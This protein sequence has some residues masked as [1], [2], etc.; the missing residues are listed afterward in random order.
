MLTGS[1]I[2]L[3]RALRAGGNGA[4]RGGIVRP[5]LGSRARRS[6]VL[7][8]PMHEIE[9]QQWKVTERD[10]RFGAP[11]RWE[12]DDVPRLIE[13][14]AAYLKRHGL[15]LPGEEKR[16]EAADFEPEAINA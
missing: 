7:N 14:E 12:R 11:L 10:F 16:L 8:T 15:F 1:R 13:F 9:P 6:E 4:A 5:T 2:I 3:A